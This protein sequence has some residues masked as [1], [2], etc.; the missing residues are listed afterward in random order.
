MTELANF[1][2]SRKQVKWKVTDN[3][4]LITVYATHPQ[5]LDHETWKVPAS[6]FAQPK[7]VEGSARV[8]RANDSWMIIAGAGRDLRFEMETLTK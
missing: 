1:L 6:R 3:G 4:G 8:V 5:S 2:N 7:I